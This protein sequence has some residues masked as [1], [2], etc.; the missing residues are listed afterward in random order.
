MIVVIVVVA[1]VVVDVVVVA[2]ATTAA[3]AAVVVLV[4]VAGT[5]LCQLCVNK[6][7]FHHRLGID[8][9]PL[10]YPAVISADTM[11]GG[12]NTGRTVAVIE[13]AIVIVMVAGSCGDDVS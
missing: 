9:K 11:A 7:C 2:A 3:E 6:E 1:A 10:R 12:G 13:P 5:I 4:V 8:F